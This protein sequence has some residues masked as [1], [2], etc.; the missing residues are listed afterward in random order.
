M[1]K[2]QESLM[3][4]TFK[5]R[6]VWQWIKMLLLN[7]ICKQNTLDV[8]W[9]KGKG[10]LNWRKLPPFLGILET[11]LYIDTLLSYFWGSGI[12]YPNFCFSVHKNMLASLSVIYNHISW[13]LN[14]S[15]FSTFWSYR[16]LKECSSHSLSVVILIR[17]YNTYVCQ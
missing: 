13:C 15:L 17:L 6:Y 10:S 16:Y 7:K 9:Y 5:A 11:S 2:S 14:K 3:K 12:V 4:P 1:S 8:I